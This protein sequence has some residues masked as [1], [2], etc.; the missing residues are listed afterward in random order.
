MAG[1]RE[2]KRERVIERVVLVISET[3]SGYSRLVT[4]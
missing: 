3:E 4:P 2:R 1:E